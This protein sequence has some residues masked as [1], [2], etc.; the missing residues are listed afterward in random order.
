[1]WT[2]LYELPVSE[3]SP[4]TG[5]VLLH[6]APPDRLQFW[7]AQ[8]ADA[9]GAMPGF[10]SLRLSSTGGSLA[11]AAAITFDTA[12]HLHD[13]LDSPGFDA[14]F[15]GDIL[16]KSSVLLL[17]DGDRL[18]PGTA[19]FR[20]DVIPARTQ[21]FVATEQEIAAATA[22]FP[23]FD[24]L[25][26]LPP[27]PGEQ[28]W[29]SILK[30]HTDE[31]LSAWLTSEVRAQRVPQL[32]SHLVKDFTID[33]PFGSILRIEDGRP[34]VTP[35]WRT[36]MLILLVLYPTAMTVTHVVA[37]WWNGLG[38][39]PWLSTWLTQILCVA[40]MTYALMPQATR[41]F[42]RWLDPV[43]GA[44]LRVS[45]VGTLVVLAVY[46]VCLSIFALLT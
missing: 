9:A 43:E 31:Q 45:V 17:V 15:S 24:S 19:V 21:E 8:V 27:L 29:V 14:A 10:V 30:L 41:R 4:A 2:H 3:V 39:H 23:G 42:A 7:R 13:W 38:A 33:A 18:P 28:Q 12:E 25:I 11:N 46:A 44:S 35:K 26:L 5:V 32:R 1:M 37:P 40:A 36:A 16:R 34:R 20:H 6:A 22:T